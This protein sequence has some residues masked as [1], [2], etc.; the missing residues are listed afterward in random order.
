MINEK[1]EEKNRREKPILIKKLNH[2][3]TLSTTTTMTKEQ[4]MSLVGG[5]KKS[6]P[7]PPPAWIQAAL[8]RSAT[9]SGKT[10]AC[11]HCDG[12]QYIDMGSPWDGLGIKPGPMC[13]DCGN[14]PP[15]LG[16][17]VMNDEW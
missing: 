10:F 6:A 12:K 3:R 11:L 14:P 13:S 17:P 16:N 8:L 1:N 9:G 7:V 15:P 2:I 4:Q 5:P